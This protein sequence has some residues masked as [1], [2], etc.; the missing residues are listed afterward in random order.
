ML[1]LLTTSIMGML[2]PLTIF[3]VIPIPAG[4]KIPILSLSPFFFPFL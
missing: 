1:A 3:H 4:Y 2:V